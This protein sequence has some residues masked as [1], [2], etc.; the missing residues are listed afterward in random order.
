[1]VHRARDQ[2]PPI[3]GMKKQRINPRNMASKH[4]AQAPIGDAVDVDVLIERHGQEALIGIQTRGSR[5]SG[6]G[7]LGML[8]APLSGL[9]GG[10]DGRGGAVRGVEVAVDGV[11]PVFAELGGVV[12]WHGSCFLENFDAS[13][14]YVLRCCLVEME[15]LQEPV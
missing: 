8:V 12:G 1:M 15:Q 14:E 11:D 5:L 6:E 2:L 4:L 13:C 7:D 3:P 10:V 9:T